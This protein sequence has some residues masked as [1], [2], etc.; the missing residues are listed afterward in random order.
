MVTNGDKWGEVC[1]EQQFIV[2]TAL[3]NC[4]FKYFRLSEKSWE[5]Y[6][7]SYNKYSGCF[8]KSG[9]CLEKEVVPKEKQKILM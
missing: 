5:D 1:V 4:K 7:S 6:L 2:S 9:L 8:N 3:T